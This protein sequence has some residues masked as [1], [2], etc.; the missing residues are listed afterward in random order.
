LFDA[1]AREA[2]GIHA[3]DR[4]GI[5]RFSPLTTLSI[6]AVKIHHDEFFNA[7]QV[8]SAAARAKHDAK[9]HGEGLVVCENT[10]LNPGGVF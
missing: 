3:K 8:A 2:G 4:H 7:E 9:I 5:S 10:N 6:G 1:P